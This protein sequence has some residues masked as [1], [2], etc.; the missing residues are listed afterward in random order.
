MLKTCSFITLYEKV[1]EKEIFK[2]YFIIAAHFVSVC[3]Q[4][5][6]EVCLKIMMSGLKGYLPPSGD[7]A[8]K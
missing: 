2:N 4:K 1:N 8:N 6:N 5:E 3:Q 7:N